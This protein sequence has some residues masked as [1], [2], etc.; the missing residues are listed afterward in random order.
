M[1]QKKKLA[2][3]TLPEFELNKDILALRSSGVKPPVL[4]D[5]RKA[6]N[7]IFVFETQITQTGI[8]SACVSALQ[9]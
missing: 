3:E 1:R 2:F 4:T 5:V 8:C 9:H 6:V 7:T